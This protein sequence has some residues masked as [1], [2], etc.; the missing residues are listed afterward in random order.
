MNTDLVYFCVFHHKDYV[1]LLR[2]LMTTIKL[3]SR[4][5]TID[6][7]VLTESKFESAIQ[8]ISTT[9]NIP[10]RM[11]FYN[12]MTNSVDVYN[13]RFCIFDYENIHNYQKI[14]YLDTDII[15]QN[16]LTT[17]F[18]H[19]IDD[20]IYAMSEGTIEHEYH[21]GW[22]FD[23]SRIDKNI[24]GMNS[25]ILLFKNTD[26]PKN[27]FRDT[28]DHIDTI[29]KVGSRM[30]LCAD[31]PFLN[32]NCIKRGGQNTVLLNKY[33]CIYGA[34]PPP[35]PSS[36]TDV[37]LCHF[38][39]PIGNA[40][41][42]KKRMISHITHLFNNYTKLLKTLTFPPIL[43][44]INKTYTWENGY[45]RF[46]DSS[47]IQTAWGNGSYKWLDEFTVEANWSIY[48]HIMRFNSDYTDYLSV[49]NSDLN[50]VKGVLDKS[51][52]GFLHSQGFYTFEGYSQQ[53]KEQVDDLIYLTNNPNVT[54]ME[55]GFNAG[56]SADVFLKNNKDLILTSFDLG[57]HD[58]GQ[59]AKKYIDTTYPN[60]HT[61][62][63]G[64][65][66]TTVPKY[67]SEHPGK[68]FDVIF[69]DGGHDYDTARA[70]FDN[71]KILANEN[72]LLI[73]DDTVFH[74]A[75]WGPPKVWTE[76]IQTNEVIE[77]AR[78][79]Y[80]RSRGMAWGKYTKNLSHQS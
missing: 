58:Y 43:N 8:E 37:I 39:W 73:F 63:L 70:D 32:F 14:L 42:K 35:P 5:D 2:I 23:F 34:E 12:I 78:R 9:L 33:I 48:S 26:L 6:F 55:I 1:E 52:T 40:N 66:K 56:H 16:D 64:D 47:N 19:D 13:R 65:S 15:V 50:C 69:I 30:P 17:L 61:L 75:D 38:A 80:S 36:P 7:L 28:I 11:K 74:W 76:A 71:C 79:S 22:F 49:R 21:G 59:T 45:I 77:I 54:V 4:T 51:I 72:T 24:S 18:E 3:Y 20:C 62:I 60:R 41:H 44:I 25:G 29:K 53:V 27:I 67:A 57:E 68:T 46:L 10:I 31:Q